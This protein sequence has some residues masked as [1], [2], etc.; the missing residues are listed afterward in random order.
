MTIILCDNG[1]FAVINRLQINQGGVPFN[2]LIA[3]AHVVEPFAVDF[4]AHAKSMGAV[5]ERVHTI[6]DLTVALGRAR[7]NDRTTVISIDTDPYTWT[8][9]GGFWEVGVPETSDRVQVREAYAELQQGKQ[10]QWLDR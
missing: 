8:G 4:A 9:G 6:N 7:S 1:G 10:A 2:N 3:D 5:V